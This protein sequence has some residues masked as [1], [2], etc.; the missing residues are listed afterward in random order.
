MVWLVHCWND[1]DFRSQFYILRNKKKILLCVCHLTTLRID[2]KNTTGTHPTLFVSHVQNGCDFG[3]CVLRTRL[4]DWILLLSC[5]CNYSLFVPTRRFIFC[6]FFFT[7]SAIHQKKSINNKIDR[8][9]N[10]RGASETLVRSLGFKRFKTDLVPKEDSNCAVC[11]NEYQIKEKIRFL[12]CRHHFHKKCIDKW[13]LL[14]K[15]W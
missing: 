10:T 9:R 11:L 14:N 6:I 13:L 4:C 3:N 8:P 12:P 2:T 7:K 1:L 15:T 5:G